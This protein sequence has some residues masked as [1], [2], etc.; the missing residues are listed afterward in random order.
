MMDF[1][2]YELK[3]ELLQALWLG[4]FSCSTAKGEVAK[5]RSLSQ[6]LFLLVFVGLPV[7]LQTYLICRFSTGFLQ[8]H[9]MTLC[10]TVWKSHW[11][12]FILGCLPVPLSMFTSLFWYSGLRD[13]VVFFG[14]M[15][16]STSSVDSPAIEL[17]LW[18]SWAE[19][20]SS[21]QSKA[22]KWGLQFCF[23]TCWQMA[24]KQQR[25]ESWNVKESYK[26]I[27]LHWAAGQLWLMES[28]MLKWTNPFS[29]F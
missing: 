23:F 27:W 29:M 3:Y 18:S 25:R 1:Y 16:L 2:I 20:P 26:F 14:C 28:S 15:K 4:P 8:L 5:R 9:L 22:Q 21:F 11:G 17:I 6:K 13:Q 10:S 24:R 12:V 7:S 19:Q